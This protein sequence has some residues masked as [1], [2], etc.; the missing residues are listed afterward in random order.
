MVIYCSVYPLPRG[1]G[2]Q[3]ARTCYTSHLRAREGPF[4]FWGTPPAGTCRT[5]SCLSLSLLGLS[6][7]GRAR[8]TASTTSPHSRPASRR[9]S[10]AWRLMWSASA[11]LLRVCWW[12][13]V[14]LLMI[15]SFPDH[16][17][18]RWA[19]GPGMEVSP[20]VLGQL[21]PYQIVGPR[22]SARN[23]RVR[24]VELTAADPRPK[25][26]RE[27]SRVRIHPLAE[28]SNEKSMLMH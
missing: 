20:G 17:S 8:R 11:S 4:H 1:M 21:R 22:P 23:R 5:V 6:F 7:Y 2:V 18:S 10:S 27:L 3:G 12:S 14:R 9:A 24:E 16:R 28:C 26:A 25:S 15:G 13:E 19:V